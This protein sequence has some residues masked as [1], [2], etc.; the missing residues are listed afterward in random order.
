MQTEGLM[1]QR[2]IVFVADLDLENIS[3]LNKKNV[4]MAKWEGGQYVNERERMLNAFVFGVAGLVKT[5]FWVKVDADVTPKG[6]KFTL[7]ES[8]FD[9][10][11]VAHRWG[12]TRVKGD[13]REGHWLNRLDEWWQQIEPDAEPIFPPNIP[14]GNR[15]GHKRI[16]SF[17]MLSKT[18]LTRK[19]V[20]LCG[21]RM[22]IP[23]QDTYVWYVATRLE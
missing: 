7:E 16:A 9:N 3:F 23:S 11:I 20:E 17:V 5:P 6:K 21:N 2:Y 1:E 10:D 12:Y 15:Y 4:V 8:M 22:P 13:E 14:T 19:A 18:E